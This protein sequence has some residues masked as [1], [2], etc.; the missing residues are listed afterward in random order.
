M[1]TSTQRSAVIARSVSHYAAFTLVQLQDD[2]LRI[3]AIVCSGLS[4]PCPAYFLAP[5]PLALALTVIYVPLLTVLD[6]TGIN[7]TFP[8]NRLGYVFTLP[9]TQYTLPA[10]KN[11]NRSKPCLRT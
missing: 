11:F 2:K 10:H 4:A 7:H 9:L 8:Q 3:V 5:C 1:Y 6:W